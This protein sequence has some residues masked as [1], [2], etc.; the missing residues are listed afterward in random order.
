MEAALQK[1]E[2]I[3]QDKI[4]EKSKSKDDEV[5]ST[6]KSSNLVGNDDQ[7]AKKSVIQNTTHLEAQISS[8]ATQK[9]T[10]GES[11]PVPIIVP[12]I[13]RPEAQR[14]SHAK[15]K[16]ATGEPVK[17]PTTLQVLGDKTTAA[18]KQPKKRRN[19]S[20]KPGKEYL[21]RVV[22]S[23]ITKSD[24]VTDKNE[25][26]RKFSKRFVFSCYTMF[27][28]Y[29]DFIYSKLT[30]WMYTTTRSHARLPRDFNQRVRSASEGNPPSWTMRRWCR[31]V[32]W[33][34]GTLNKVEA[35]S[36]KK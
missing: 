18:Q 31:F 16:N 24:F 22:N 9:N 30:E 29:S 5:H 2:E 34:N 19:F 36:A 1:A 33:R 13:T 6:T 20:I 23:W 3:Q 25:S 35:I 17:Q 28:T 11:V 14:T 26:M 12:N 10:P 27:H 15:E 4:S 7:V 21:D 8:H 32:N